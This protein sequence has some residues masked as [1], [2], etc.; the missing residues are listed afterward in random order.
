[1]TKA[2]TFEVALDNPK[3]RLLDQ[4]C[5]DTIRTLAMDGVQKLSLIHI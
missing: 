4:L 1:M 3:T 2:P 5:I